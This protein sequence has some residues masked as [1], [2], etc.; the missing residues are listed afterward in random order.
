MDICHIGTLSD[1]EKMKAI[2]QYPAEKVHQKKLSLNGFPMLST[3]NNCRIH[4]LNYYRLTWSCPKAEVSIPPIPYDIVIALDAVYNSPKFQMTIFMFQAWNVQM[5]TNGT[6]EADYL[7]VMAKTRSTLAWQGINILLVINPL[8]SI[9]RIED[10]CQSRS[11]RRCWTSLCPLSDRLHRK[12]NCEINIRTT[13]SLRSISTSAFSNERN[14]RYGKFLLKSHPARTWSFEGHRYPQRKKSARLCFSDSGG[15]DGRFWRVVRY[16]K[17]SEN[18][19][20]R[21]FAVRNISMPCFCAHQ[22]RRWYPAVS[23]ESV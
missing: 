4:L 15:D 14:I 18:R 11:L 23:L 5:A 3:E 10:L 6:Q 12:I 13:V 8:F 16:T 21:F 7:K 19:L 9:Y 20:S 17:H 22:S 1:A 2:H